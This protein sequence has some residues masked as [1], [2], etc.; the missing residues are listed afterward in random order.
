MLPCFVQEA[1]AERAIVALR[2]S[3]RQVLAETTVDDAA[4]L[5][6]AYYAGVFGRPSSAL[7]DPLARLHDLAGHMA[8]KKGEHEKAVEE[9]EQ[10]V[11][12][13]ERRAA[14]PRHLGARRDRVDARTPRTGDAQRRSRN[15]PRRRR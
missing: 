12:D 15:R 14:V 6:A 10:A 5:Y 3:V 13:R 7:H 9:L 1:G 8:L 2:E 11:R 4:G